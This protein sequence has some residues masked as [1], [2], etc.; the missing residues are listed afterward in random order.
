[1]SKIDR[2]LIPLRPASCSRDSPRLTRT[3]SSVVLSVG[4]TLSVTSLEEL[5]LT[6]RASLLHVCK[7][8]DRGQ[9]PYDLLRKVY[10]LPQR[11]PIGAF[12]PV[13]AGM[14]S[15]WTRGSSIDGYRTAWA[16]AAFCRHR[17]S[18]GIVANLRQRLNSDFEH[19][20][21]LRLGTRVAPQATV[22][23]YPADG[24]DLVAFALVRDWRR[25]VRPELPRPSV[26]DPRDDPSGAH[27]LLGMAPEEMPAGLAVCHACTI[28]FE[29]G[30][31]KRARL[32]GRCG[33][34]RR[35]PPRASFLT[36]VPTAGEAVALRITEN[37]WT[38]KPQRERT[39]YVVGCLE[40]GQLFTGKRGA[41]FCSA[42]CERRHARRAA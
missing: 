19:G 18:E 40:C 27:G 4:D 8:S 7:P 20:L 14:V 2:A 30:R 3:R 5:P 37:V 25:A 10:E 11:V 32:C 39:I 23:H 21:R 33:K 38:I 12:V 42:K 29:P 41:T 6:P 16:M 28:V 26:I 13:H 17:R 31:K 15:A 24:D 1:M 35:P 36:R 9:S 34:Q 22:A